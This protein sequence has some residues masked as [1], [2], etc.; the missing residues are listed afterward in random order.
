[1]LNLEGKAT[2]PGAPE[3][4]FDRLLDPAVLKRCITGCESLEPTGPGAYLAVVKFGVGA[5]KG[6]FRATLTVSEVNRP[7]SCRI[8]I[9]G[10]SPVGYV[11]G[12][13]VVTLVADGA[14][15]ALTYAGEGKISGM[16]AAVGQRLIGAASQKCADEFFE[17]FARV[18]AGAAP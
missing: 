5:I 9:E 15:T 17:R 13:A 18:L 10:K 11:Q 7:S 2:L 3:M 8:A 1:M 14:G 12:G 6:T 4:V 16:L